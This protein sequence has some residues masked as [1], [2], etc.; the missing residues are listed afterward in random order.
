MSTNP[1]IPTSN[2]AV[3]IGNL[4]Q[5]PPPAAQAPQAIN[6]IPWTASP[7]TAQTPTYSPQVNGVAEFGPSPA[8]PTHLPIYTNNPVNYAWSPAA[9][10]PPPRAGQFL[11]AAPGSFRPADD[12]AIN[13][14]KLTGLSYASPADAPL[15]GFC[16]TNATNPG[17]IDSVCNSLDTN[18][19][20][21][22]QCCVLIGG[23]GDGSA[24]GPAAGRCVAGGENGPVMTSYYTDPTIMH[25]DRYYY[26]GKCYGNCSNNPIGTP[27]SPQVPAAPLP[28]APAAAAPAAAAPAAPAPAAPAAPAHPLPPGTGGVKPTVAASGINY[29]V[30]ADAAIVA[31]ALL[32]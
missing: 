16:R 18:V 10:T 31:G 22:T 5:T 6:A 29:A 14:S 11:L 4:G 1:P 9:S 2:K 3:Y 12:L 15:G 7:S 24:G 20:A 25:R 19:C 26:Q 28:T 30:L 8:T 13:Y 23:S 21:S 32:L 17:Q 27:S